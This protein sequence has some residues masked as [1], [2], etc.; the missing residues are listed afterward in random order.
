MVRRL[1]LTGEDLP[2][3]LPG[4]QR[5]YI[6]RL[7]RLHGLPLQFL[8]KPDPVR[9][10]I[11]ASQSVRMDHLALLAEADVRGRICEDQQ[12]L[13]TRIA[14]FREFCQ[15]Q[16]C[17]SQPYA[18]A[19]PHS[20]F[21]YVHSEQADPTYAAYDTT[22]FEVVLMSGLPGSGKDTWIQ[23]HLPDLPVISLDAIRQELKI[24]P[25][26]EQGR[27]VQLARERARE[28]LRQ[29]QPFVWNATNIS[30][31]LRQQLVDLFVAYD[32]RVR[33]VYLEV[34]LDVLLQ[35]NH[36]RSAGLPEQAINKMLDK[37][38]PPDITEAHEV[39]WIWGDAI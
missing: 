12:E 39:T 30:K 3:P 18:F 27:V 2:A 4:I 1:L 25:T 9:T 11:T 32:A 14:L 15:E 20:R 16:A 28:F 29:Q 19:T 13:L 33:I 23:T 24:S 6:A 26:A 34:P 31:M 7:V 22:K 8:D 36:T 10:V 35:R 37:L 21:V 5:E 17:Y 38:E